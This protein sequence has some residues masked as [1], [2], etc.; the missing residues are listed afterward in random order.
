MSKRITLFLLM[1][2]PTSIVNVFSQANAG[3]DQEICT[4][5]SYMQAVDPF[6]NTG[7]WEA[8]SGSGL[9]ENPSLFNSKVT[10]VGHGEN[11]FRWVVSIESILYYD[12][13]TITNNSP[14][15]ARIIGPVDMTTCDGTITLTAE[16]PVPYYECD[17]YWTIISGA[18]NITSQSNDFV[19]NVS[20]LSGGYNSFYW[21]LSN[22]FCTNFDYITIINN[23]VEAHAGTDQTICSDSTFLDA[24]NPEYCF[25]LQGTGHWSNLSG[26]TA[27]IEN[28]YDSVSHISNLPQ[29]TTILQWTVENENCSADDLVT[30]TNNEVI[31][32]ATN[33]EGCTG[34][35]ELN[36][37]DPNTFGG[38]GYWEIF[39]GIGTLI[40]PTQFNTMITGVPE[41]ATTTLIWRVTNGICSDSILVSVSNNDFSLSAGADIAQCSDCYT[42]AGDPVP[43][44]G[45]GKWIIDAG[46][47]TFENWSMNNVEVCGLG[48]GINTISWTVTNAYGCTNSDQVN[49]TNNN[50]STAQIIIPVTGI[51]ET[52]DG[53]FTIEAN[54][55][56][57]GTGRWFLCSGSA[58]ISDDTNY[59][60]SLTEL[61]FGPNVFGWHISNADCYSQADVVIVNYQVPETEIVIPLNDTVIYQDFIQLM[62]VEPIIG[63]GLWTVA[64]PGISFTNATS[65]STT[66]NNI[67]LGSHLFTWTVSNN[68]CSPS[69]NSVTVTRNELKAFAGLDFYL[70]NYTDSTFLNASLPPGANGYWYVLQGNGEVVD[71]TD[72]HS[73]VKNLSVGDNILRWT[74]SYLK[75]GDDDEIIITKLTEPIYAGPDQN[76][77]TNATYLQAT[78]PT[79]Y[80]GEWI[81]VNGMATIANPFQY[82]TLVTNLGSGENTFRWEVIIE[83]ET[84]FDYVTITNNALN[85]Y[86]GEDQTL[87][88]MTDET[89]FDADLEADQTGYWSIVSGGAHITDINDPVSFV[90]DLQ[91]GMNTFRW[92]VSNSIGCEGSDEMNILVANFIP[93]AG[94]DLIV[95]SDTAK[96]NATFVPNANDQRWSIISGAGIF[97]DISDPKTVVRNILWGANIYRWTVYFP[98]YSDYDDVVITYDYI[99]VSAGEDASVCGDSYQMDAQFIEGAVHLWTPIGLGGGTIIDNSAWNTLV[100][101]LP[102]GQNVFNWFVD[103]GNCQSNDI[104][105]IERKAEPIADFTVTPEEFTA[106]Q[107]VLIENSSTYVPGFTEPDEFTWFINDEFLGTTFNYDAFYHTFT[108]TGTSDSIFNI[109]LIAADNE[110]GCIDTVTH[111]ILAH[112]SPESVETISSN[113]KLYPNPANDKITIESSTDLS[114]AVIEIENASGQSVYYSL[115]NQNVKEYEIDISALA[116]G[117][118]ILKITSDNQI[119]IMKFVKK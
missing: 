108:N 1:F 32:S 45:T 44:G 77:C 36:G 109:E 15:E 79:P 59:Q 118:Y 89:Y 94:P 104:V 20:D 7:Y 3:P 99:F 73:I 19:I 107:E 4:D 22:E 84:L 119:K 29:G 47:G 56:P 111:T 51:G 41:G 57:F 17:H 87:P 113:F 6:P 68:I 71:P 78:D 93:N 42:L 117:F 91:N 23:Q 101:N 100:T 96:L 58:T 28:I 76:I 75:T 50:P 49:I 92:N 27:I 102:I 85:I 46:S 53:T 60:T 39:A 38:T 13:M 90:Y 48:H 30:I 61:G 14:G 26:N 40:E 54:N 110:T 62:A 35:F 55:P 72:P 5:S 66:A 95:C 9:I 106:P 63:T 37:N 116:N 112:P 12:T 16:V 74:V 83:D 10:L 52:C 103:N 114:D 98:G 65:F 88:P 25:P 64:T 43:I 80:T 97:D 11:V 21:N 69:T 67:P 18:W 115:L 33:L 70:P 24:V 105:I 81:L 31:A 8:I 34:D 2:I 82:N 86:A